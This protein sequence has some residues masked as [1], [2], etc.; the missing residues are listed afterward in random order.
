L[1]TVRLFR[2]PWGNQSLLSGACQNFRGPEGQDDAGHE[3]QDVVPGYRTRAASAKPVPA[4]ISGQL[5]A[6]G[7]L[8]SLAAGP[9]M[10]C[11]SRARA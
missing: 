9:P 11:R 5:L 2:P 6:A 8:I 3:L 4:K 10:P 7:E 1:L